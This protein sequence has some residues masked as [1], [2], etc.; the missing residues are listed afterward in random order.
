MGF[1]TWTKK[2]LQDLRAHHPGGAKPGPSKVRSMTEI[3]RAW[4]GAFIEA[5]G[6]AF[7]NSFN[8][9]RSDALIVAASQKEIDPIATLLRIT[10]VGIIQC[11]KGGSI[12][13]WR[14]SRRNDVKNL[15]DQCA[16]YSWKLQRE[17]VKKER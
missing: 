13:S 15:I 9:N 17:L 10:G 16:P 2:E 6:C 14:I 8:D 1:E 11:S 3:E 5:D 4:V 7:T 12:W